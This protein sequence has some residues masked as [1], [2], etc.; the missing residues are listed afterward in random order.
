[1]ESIDPGVQALAIHHDRTE[2]LTG[3]RTQFI[4]LTEWVARCVRR[5]GVEHGMAVVRVLHTTA[6]IVVNENEPL[7]LDDLT[8]MLERLAPG[9]VAYA[10]DDP[11]RRRV[12]LEPGE[13]RNGHSHARALLLGDSKS[14]GVVEG[15]LQRG[16]WQSIFLVELDG[17]RRR[18]IVVT[19]MGYRTE[20]TR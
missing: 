7:L 8:A 14:I 13:R 20:P 15:D 16:R 9:D 17:P 5:S 4:D 12:K 2:I 10:H 11:L 18:S 6:A 19:V 1:M 3:Q